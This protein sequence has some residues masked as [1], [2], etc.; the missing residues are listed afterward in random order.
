MTFDDPELVAREY[1]G[2]TRFAARRVAFSEF[3]EGQTAE[4]LAIEALREMAPSWVL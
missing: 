3:V 1:E 4:E 2:E